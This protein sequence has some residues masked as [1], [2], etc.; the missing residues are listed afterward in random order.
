MAVVARDREHNDRI[1]SFLDYLLAEWAAVP[2]LAVEWADWS[3]D[4]RADFALDW[5]IRE[6][7]LGQ[8]EQLAHQGKLSA[9]QAQRYAR[10]RE[11]VATHRP[12]LDRLFCEAGLAPPRSVA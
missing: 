8:L 6:D 10:L 7:R 5:P 3:A 4:D 1:E 9:L 2:D 11:L 12:L